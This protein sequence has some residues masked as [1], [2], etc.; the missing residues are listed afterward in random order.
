M[1]SNMLKCL[2]FVNQKTAYEMRNRDWSSDVCSS[3]LTGDAADPAGEAG[4]DPV[5][6]ED[7]GEAVH[8]VAL[9]RFGTQLGHRNVFA[10]LHKTVADIGR[11][12][13]D[14]SSEVRRV[15]K[16]CVSPCSIRGVPCNL[17][18]NDIKMRNITNK[19]Y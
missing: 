19:C 1:K 4:T 8:C 5:G 16:E 6:Q 9:R 10:D 3:D 18:N 14:A 2:F 15:G 17:K 12:Y 7:R 11:K 13:A